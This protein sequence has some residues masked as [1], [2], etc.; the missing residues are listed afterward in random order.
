LEQTDTAPLQVL[1]LNPM[2]PRFQ[3]RR[4]LQHG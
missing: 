4:E 2:R 1:D 3:P